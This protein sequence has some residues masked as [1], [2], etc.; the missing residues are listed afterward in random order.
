MINCL[1]KLIE[2]EMAIQKLGLDV[3]PDELLCAKLIIT[4]YK[5]PDMDEIFEAV[6]IDT[7][8]TFT[9][10]LKICLFAYVKE[11]LEADIES[12]LHT[13]TYK[14]SKEEVSEFLKKYASDKSG[15]ISRR[16]RDWVIDAE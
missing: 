1:V 12:D 7:T 11:R 16:Y 9:D 4:R 14:Y 6:K 3:S 10:E 15:R 2:N 5:A 13:L 8:N